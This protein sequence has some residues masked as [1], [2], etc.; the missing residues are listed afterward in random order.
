MK[1]AFCPTVSEPTS[2]SSTL[3][4]SRRRVRS[5]TTVNSVTACS[6]AATALPGSTLRVSTTPLMGERIDAFERLVSSVERAA[7]ASSTD[8]RALASSALA[9]SSVAWPASS[10]V[11]D[12]TLPPDRRATSCKRARP[13]VA[14]L[15]VATACASRAWAAASDA[16]E[17]STCASSLAVSS[18]TSTWPFLT[19]SFTSTSTLRTV[20]ESSLPIVTDRVGC[21]VPLAATLSVRL[22]RRT[23]S[24]T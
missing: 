18:S 12:G 8:A 5:S 6:D 23:S 11:A 16:R 20:P 3:T 22:P 2:A 15:V 17:R 1:L 9:R 4:S 21:K 7:R 14:S 10:S 13:A 24:V 19:L